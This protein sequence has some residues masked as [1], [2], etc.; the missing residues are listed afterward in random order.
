MEQ[1]EQT[2]TFMKTVIKF[3]RSN[4]CQEKEEVTEGHSC[5]DLFLAEESGLSGGSRSPLQSALL[6]SQA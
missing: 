1:E 4:W 3:T 2:C 6:W 5:A